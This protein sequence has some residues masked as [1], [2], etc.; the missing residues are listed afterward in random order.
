MI[1]VRGVEDHLGRPV[2]LLELDDHRVREIAIE[3]EQVARLGA[4]P[5][6]DRL[7][8]VPDDGEVARRLGEPAHEV[9][10]D[11]VGVLELVDQDVAEP[12][13]R[14][15]RARDL[16]LPPGQHLQQQVV[17]VDRVLLR[18]WPWYSG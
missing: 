9:V 6:V 8:V 11:A 12:D 4:A 10:L 3:V 13:A 16:G 7:V 17:E 18:S 5:R 14:A 2:V 1:A 15:I